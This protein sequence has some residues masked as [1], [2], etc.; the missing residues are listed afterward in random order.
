MS[1]G[2]VKL[3]DNDDGSIFRVPVDL[4]DVT[5]V[6]AGDS[7]CVALKRDGTVVAWGSN[8][9]GQI[10]VPDGLVGVTAIVAGG[11]DSGAVLSDG[12][13]VFWGALGQAVGRIAP[14]TE[15]VWQPVQFFALDVGGTHLVVADQVGLSGVA[16]PLPDAL[17]PVDMPYGLANVVE[18][19]AG[20]G[21]CLAHAYTAEGGQIVAWGRNDYG[22]CDVPGGLHNLRMIS[23]GG[24]VSLAL[25]ADGSV[26]AWGY[27]FTR[28]NETPMS[29][30]LNGIVQVAA[31]ERCLALRADGT[32]ISWGVENDRNV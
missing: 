4:T 31:G 7:H 19:S 15:S 26:E 32:I 27:P 5:A 3:W 23:A 16:M 29:E 18:L 12:T 2:T 6:A 1:D 10:D 17:S 22:Q 25:R 8:L 9:N 24:S 14:R 11:E 28:A 13:A 20:S 21:H 30:G